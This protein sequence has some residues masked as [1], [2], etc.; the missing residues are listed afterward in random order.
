VISVFGF[1]PSDSGLISSVTLG[2]F[3]LAG[4]GA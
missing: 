3:F 4:F 1:R 2:A